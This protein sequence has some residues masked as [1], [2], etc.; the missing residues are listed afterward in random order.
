MRRWRSARALRPSSFCCRPG[1]RRAPRSRSRRAPSR[2][3]PSRRSSEPRPEAARPELPVAA[4]PPYGVAAH[5]SAAGSGGQ[6]ALVVE[7]GESVVV[8][9]AE[10]LDDAWVEMLAG[11][12]ANLGECGL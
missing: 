7:S 3:P 10:R 11:L 12:L 1:A 9:G 4:G 5:R 6:R 2:R 8:E